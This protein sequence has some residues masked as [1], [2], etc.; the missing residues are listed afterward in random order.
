MVFACSMPIATGNMQSG[1]DESRT[2][3]AFFV[4]CLWAFVLLCRPQDLFPFLAN[5]SPAL[6]G[7][8]LTLFL[9]FLQ[10]KDLPG[11]R[12]FRERQIKCFAALVL[13]MILGVPFSLY[14]R[15]SFEI[16]FT[17]Y[18]T[19]IV[20]VFVFYKLVST[21][22][23]LCTLLLLFCLG[24]ALYSAFALAQ[25]HSAARLAYGGMFDPNDMAFVNLGFLPLNLLFISR[26]NSLWIR[27][28]CL[29][30]FC[31]SA[32]V[33]LQTESRGGF[34]AFGVALILLLFLKTQ[35]V[36]FSLK[37]ALVA[38]LVAI[39]S[40]ASIDTERY[41]TLLELDEDYNLTSNT[42]RIAIWK[43]GFK[44]M[45]NNPLTGVGVGNYAMVVGLERQKRGAETRSWQTAHNSP[46]Q[47]GTETG[48]IGFLLF[49]G[50]SIN[51]F[52]VL[53]KLRKSS[54]KNLAKIGEMGFVGFA[55]LFVSGLFLSQAYSAYWA[56]YVA[57][58]AVTHQMLMKENTV[59]DPQT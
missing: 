56:F 20:F 55:G 6:A 15:L 51:V 9:V 32:L 52:I 36:T 58:S 43:I 38:A 49:L 27:L 50:A 37:V 19:T 18:L 8:I 53:N 5:F 47:I 2:R 45:L 42:G 31:I 4:F 46:I 23:R 1:K 7:G 48:V 12:L 39:I 41:K 33:I 34:L 11:P 26:D 24:N 54:C 59:T 21:I 25:S 28:A 29:C 13:I 30:A 44:A 17:V 14:A 10:L 3:I 57:L 35:T 40:F 16:V 22:Y